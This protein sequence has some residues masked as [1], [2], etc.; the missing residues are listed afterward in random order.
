MKTMSLAALVLLAMMSG[1][2]AC[3]AIE[4][5]G[6]PTD[7]RPGFQV[8]L[9]RMGYFSMYNPALKT[10]RWVAEHIT[11]AS[12]TGIETRRDQ[13]KDDPD[14]PDSSE[15]VLNDYRASGYAR[16]HMA[17]AGDFPHS[18]EAMTESFYLTNMVPQIQRCNNAGIW[19]RIERMTR[20]WA[21]HYGEVY[22][23]TGP[24][25]ST[26]PVRTI[27]RGVGVPDAVFKVIYNPKLNTS[28]AFLVP[29]VEMCGA[30]P[31]SVATTQDVIEAQTGLQFF[32]KFADRGYLRTYQIWE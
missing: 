14:V 25:Y 19:S 18:A 23:V 26:V 15:A 10:P 30:T 22:V 21:I 31:K 32:P 27:G 17:P 8:P 2:H 7:L 6:E 5:Q 13:F 11:G 28:L 12:V 16:G 4:T 24:V 3:E 1:A 20:E 9:C 29:N